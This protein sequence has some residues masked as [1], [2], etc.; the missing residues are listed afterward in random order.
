MIQDNMRYPPFPAF[1]RF[2]SENDLLVKATGSLA[3]KLPRIVGQGTTRAVGLELPPAP[4]ERKI[5]LVSLEIPGGIKL[6]ESVLREIEN[7]QR[8]L[9]QELREVTT[10]E[11]SRRLC[12]HVIGGLPIKGGIK[13]NYFYAGRFLLVPDKKT[14]S[15]AWSITPH[16]PIIS[17]IPPDPDYMIQAYEAAE[18]K[19]VEVVMDHRDFELKL[20]L[21]W[22]MARH[23]SRS[24]EVLIVDVARMFLISAQDNKFWQSPQRKFYKD[25]PQAAFI[26]NFLS[27]KQKQSVGDE[28]KFELI[29]AVLNQTLRSDAQVF[30]LPLDYEGTQT[31]PY[32]YIRMRQS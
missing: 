21:A 26:S 11:G 16:Y 20:G 3:A 6:P 18:K 5:E 17:K 10:E 15:W 24:D 30:Y 29:P 12:S 25:L 9:D 19:V 31:R 7:V 23:F 8:E 14:L 2:V 1:E 4:I 27:W 32:R 28:A 22:R 13:N